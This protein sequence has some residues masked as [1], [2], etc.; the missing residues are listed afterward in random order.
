MQ[1]RKDTPSYTLIG[2]TKDR[3][4]GKYI[5]HELSETY[6]KEW[7]EYHN[8]ENSSTASKD[9]KAKAELIAKHAQKQQIR[10]AQ[11][12]EGRKEQSSKSITTRS[13]ARS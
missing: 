10:I 5:S 7:R 12:Q 9:S 8:R 11:I 2:E 6:K 4:W 13:R 3:M 1:E